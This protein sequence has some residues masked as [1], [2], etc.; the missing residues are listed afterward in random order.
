M[1]TDL[2][3]TAIPVTGSITLTN[4]NVAYEVQLPAAT[5]SIMLEMKTNAGEVSFTGTDTVD[6]GDANMALPSDTWV[7]L[8]IRRSRAPGGEVS[9]YLQT[10][11]GG[12]KC[13]Y[14][15]TN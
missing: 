9:I 13:A 6:L 4:A 12:T 14:T 7:D 11:T 3:G 1:A 15:L 2:T 8:D 5:R 10:A